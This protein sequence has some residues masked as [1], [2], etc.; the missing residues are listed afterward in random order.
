[1]N[2]NTHLTKGDL[3]PN[4]VYP[5]RMFRDIFTQDDIDKAI[6]NGYSNIDEGNDYFHYD[7]ASGLIETVN[8][9]DV[10]HFNDGGTPE[11]DKFTFYE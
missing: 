11:S 9:E 10:L 4:V 7:S 6:A 2:K 3:L 8:R 5:M 1:M